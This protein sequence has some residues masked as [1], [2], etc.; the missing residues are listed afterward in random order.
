[1]TFGQLLNTVDFA[2]KYG[3]LLPYTAERSVGVDAL[4]DHTGILLMGFS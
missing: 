4:P 1:V 3:P 2:G